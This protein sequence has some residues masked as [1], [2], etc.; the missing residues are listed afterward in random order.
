[1]NPNRRINAFGRAPFDPTHELKLLGTYR[2]PLWGGFNLSGV[3]RYT[4]GYA[5]GRRAVIRGLRH[6]SERVWVEP[7][8]TRRLPPIRQLDLRVET[9][10]SLGA[11]G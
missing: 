6:G 3:Y 10:F 8:G 7:W 4:T 2:L 11:T 9:T 1:M 5:W